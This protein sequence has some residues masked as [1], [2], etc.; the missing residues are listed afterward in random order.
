MSVLLWENQKGEVHKSEE[1][2]DDRGHLCDLV[3][4]GCVTE[5]KF[6]EPVWGV[7]GIILFLIK[8]SP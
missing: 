1:C 6:R 2:G 4:G 5:V 8:K 7:L 3:A